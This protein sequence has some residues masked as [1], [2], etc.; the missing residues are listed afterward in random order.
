MEIA[1]NHAGS[2]VKCILDFLDYIVDLLRRGG[3]AYIH[4]MTGVTRS[5]FLAAILCSHI[6]CEP[7]DV[8]MRRI[9]GLRYTDVFHPT[10]NPYGHSGINGDR[11]QDT[12]TFQEQSWVKRVCEA[13]VRPL[14][15]NGMYMVA[16]NVAKELRMVHAC[17]V[18]GYP[19]C[20]M[21]KGDGKMRGPC[22]LVDSEAEAATQL[23]NRICRDCMM[24]LDIL[25]VA[26]LHKAGFSVKMCWR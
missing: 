15:P 26:R 25:S 1:V 2:R 6:H 16:K 8:S 21:K 4:C 13:P 12:T 19:L 18:A 17:Q 14:A 9:L 22:E 3:N 10:L 23:G 24:R 11:G 7:I 20:Y 5:I